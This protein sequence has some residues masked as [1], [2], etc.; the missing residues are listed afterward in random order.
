MPALEQG[1]DSVLLADSVEKLK[2]RIFGLFFGIGLI[3]PG[4][5][6]SN[7]ERL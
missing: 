3:F 4:T 6:S 2:Y 5:G 1:P 7:T